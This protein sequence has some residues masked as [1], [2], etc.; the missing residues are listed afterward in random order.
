MLYRILTED[1]QPDVVDSLVQQYLED[2]TV[3]RARGVWR[4]QWENSLI[5]SVS[6]AGNDETRLVHD[7]VLALAAAIK[8]VNQQEAVLVQTFACE[9]LLV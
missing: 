9:S 5:I 6:V 2:A 1:K 8:Q 4:R 3:S 7:A